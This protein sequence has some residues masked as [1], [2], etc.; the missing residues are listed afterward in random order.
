MTVEAQS[1]YEFQ[2]FFDNEYIKVEKMNICLKI[3]FY[4][5]IF[6]FYFAI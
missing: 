1:S 6:H 5:H 4:W 2:L 3:K